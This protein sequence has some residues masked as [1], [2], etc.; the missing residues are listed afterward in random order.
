MTWSSYRKMDETNFLEENLA[1]KS[2]NFPNS[3]SRE[4]LVVESCLTPLNDHKT[5]FTMIGL[6]HVYP[7]DNRKFLKNTIFCFCCLI[8]TKLNGFKY[9]VNHQSQVHPW[10]NYMC[11]QKCLFSF[12]FL[13]LVMKFQKFRYHKNYISHYSI[14]R[15]FKMTKRLIFLLVFDTIYTSRTKGNGLK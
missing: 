14:H 5:W 9:L 3:I 6:R 1:Q 4:Q 2:Q 11:P 13:S 15:P 10:D 7:S 12:F 8:K